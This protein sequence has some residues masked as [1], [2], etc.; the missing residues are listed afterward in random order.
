[1]WVSL[2]ATPVRGG[3]MPNPDAVANVVVLVA[4]GIGAI[5]AVV[6]LVQLWRHR[7]RDDVGGLTYRQ[8]G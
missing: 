3:V 8:R 4:A 7:G 6:C 5:A 1:M 2:N